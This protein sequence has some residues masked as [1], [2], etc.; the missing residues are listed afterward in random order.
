MD[1]FIFCRNYAEP[2]PIFAKKQEQYEKNNVNIP[3]LLQ[4]SLSCLSNRKEQ[5][6]PAFILLQWQSSGGPSVRTVQVR[7]RKLSL[8]GLFIMT[9]KRLTDFT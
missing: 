1:N 2:K 6:N 5:R 4:K 8:Q 3:F 9:W 7:W